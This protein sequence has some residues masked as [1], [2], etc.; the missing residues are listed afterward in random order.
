M[1]DF[2]CVARHA[3]RIDDV[4]IHHSDVEL[5]GI[6]DELSDNSTTRLAVH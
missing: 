6:D 3:R 2:S 1:P 4:D 5:I